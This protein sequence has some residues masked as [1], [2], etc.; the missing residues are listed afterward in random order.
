MSSNNAYVFGDP[1]LDRQ[2]L[3]TQSRLI[4]RYVRA[5]AQK[6]CG[7]EVESILDVGCG[8]GQLGFA[9]QDVYVGATLTGIDRDAHAAETA[10]ARAQ[11]EFRSATFVQGDVQQ[12]LPLGP[13]D[14][15]FMSLLLLHT[16]QPGAVL[17]N[18]Y[19]VMKPGACLWIIDATEAMG[20]Q[21]GD[22]PGDWL[23]GLFFR[24]LE[25]I[26]AHPHIMSELPGLLAAAGFEQATSHRDD[27]FATNNQIEREQVN[28]AGLGAI[29][30]AR[31]MLA[32]VNDIPIYQIDKAFAE[33]ADIIVRNPYISM[34]P[35]LVV[36]TAHK[37]EQ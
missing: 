25:K 11:S 32:R 9:L 37:P 16:Q 5:S 1:E 19:K 8:E 21:G 22:S 3:E 4:A 2:R 34:D 23:F 31:E 35:V 29:Y 30:N 15:V 28:A 18:A 10:T 7:D 24:T 20:G 36:V 6:L 14:L 27:P 33:L 12:S 13:Y 26:G 17:N